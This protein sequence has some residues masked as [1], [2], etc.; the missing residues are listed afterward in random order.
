[1]GFAP[2]TCPSCHKHIQVPLDS[3]ESKC[4]YCGGLVGVNSHAPSSPTVL[5]LLG[6]ARTAMTAGNQ[7]EAESYYNRVLELDPEISE[8]WIGK[9]KSA[10]WQSTLSNMR[11][12]EILT[13]F[14][15]AI[16]TASPEEKDATIES[17]VF[18]INH[19]VVTLYGMSRKHML[20][21]VSLP[22]TWPAYISN[23]GAMLSTLE[24]TSS[25]RPSERTTL[26]NI[27]HL[28][29]D[30]IEGVAY[31]D[32]LDRNLPKSWKLS[33]QYEA[34]LRQKMDEAAKAIR[35]LDPEYIAPQAET[36]KPD[37]C[38]VVT[39]TMGEA[40]HPTV[41]FLRRFRDEWLLRK[42]GGRSFVSWYYKHGPKAAAF[43][44]VSRARRR[45]SYFVLVK[46][47]SFV[48]HLLMA[49]LEKD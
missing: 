30:N 17:C 18:E 6:M 39:A 2:A 23:V 27:V 11:F 9:G 10:G 46:P 45:I 37:A 14:G 31:R 4:M 34:Q 25:W 32:E 29:K 47:L 8:A 28:C 24:T 41:V 26:E 22:D 40:D 16:A 7:A 33:D 43:V 35:L 44:S 3:D 42:P 49:R 12:G 19:L 38:F 48:A 5:N 15:H 21:F 36:K 13:C 20:E 1:M